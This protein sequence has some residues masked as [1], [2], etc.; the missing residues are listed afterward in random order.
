MRFTTTFILLFLFVFSAFTQNNNFLVKENAVWSTVEVHCLP[1]GN[2]YSTHHIKFEGDTL[3]ENNFYKKIFRCNDESQ[4]DWFYSGMIR[5]DEQNR[6]FFKP[7]GYPEGMVYHFGVSVND[8]ITAV[9][10][11]LNA[12]DTLHFVVTT[13][14]SVELLN[15]YRKRIILH[16]YVN[17]KE[18]TWVEGLGSYYGVLN[19]CNNAYGAICG[20]YEA[21]CY[22]EDESLIYQNQL[23]QTCH[24]AA[25][26]DVEESGFDNI[27]IYPNPAADMLNINFSHQ[28]NLTEDLVLTMHSIDGK[29]IL[30]KKLAKIKNAVYLQ[31]VNKGVY[32]INIRGSQFNLPSY[33]ILVD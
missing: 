1:N 17:D 2:L 22:K 32:I 26:V 21:L 3:F 7:P 5:E 23:Y 10:T 16:E 14:D 8:T 20:G 15:G 29:K 30:E 31:K 24:Y 6:V 28:L 11:Y 27:Q 19:S 18:E 9:N 12:M 4:I 25:L 33:K 13:V